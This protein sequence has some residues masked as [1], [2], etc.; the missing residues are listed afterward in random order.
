M[1]I[2]NNNAV[3]YTKQTTKILPLYI[4]VNTVYQTHHEKTNSPATKTA[5]VTCSPE[6]ECISLTL[7]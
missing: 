3:S 7:T 1:I 4:Q 6:T 2:V 5:L